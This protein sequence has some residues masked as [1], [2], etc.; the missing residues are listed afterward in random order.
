MLITIIIEQYKHDRKQPTAYRAHIY[1]YNI[2]ECIV[3]IYSINS[4]KVSFSFHFIAQKENT[5]FF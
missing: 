1:V 4:Q 3:V 2:L 5:R